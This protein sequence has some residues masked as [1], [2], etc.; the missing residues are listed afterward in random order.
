ML[1]L[2][3]LATAADHSHL[4][5]VTHELLGTPPA[6][7]CTARRRRLAHRVESPPDDKSLGFKVRYEASQNA[8][9]TLP[10]LD[11]AL[12]P[13]IA[14]IVCDNET[15]VT[16]RLRAAGASV[17]TATLVERFVDGAIMTGACTSEEAE[18][19]R[20]FYRTA[21]AMRFIHDRLG[22]PLVSF[23]SSPAE[24]ASAFDALS[25]R[26]E[27]SRMRPLEAAEEVEEALTAEEAAA[28]E[29][30]A[31]D[32]VAVEAA[33]AA[34]DARYRAHAR[35]LFLDRVLPGNVSDTQWH[36]I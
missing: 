16:L 15:H 22:R 13:H 23:R 2:L 20:P 19:P 32:V 10:L 5:R 9:H 11:Q 4:F 25:I 34:D 27:V 3:A 6:S 36:S 28:V 26:I 1:V 12:A 30:T 31:A 21:H 7:A 29:A 24:F 33:A 18:A 14:S 17:V 8:A 35:G